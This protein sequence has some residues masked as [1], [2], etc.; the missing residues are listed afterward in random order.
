[1]ATLLAYLGGLCDWRDDLKPG[2]TGTGLVVAADLRQ[3]RSVLSYAEGALMGGG[4]PLQ[5]VIVSRTADAIQLKNNIVL[6]A[7]SANFRRLRG[8]TAIAVVADEIAFWRTDEHAANPDTE[9]L[10]A[11]RPCLATTG[12]PL[13]AA[14]SPYARRGE[15]YAAYRSH[16]GRDGDPRILVA[17]AA[18]RILNP[19][20]PQS[21][22]DRAMER[23]PA[24]ARAEYGAEFRS[25]VESFIPQETVDAS[26]DTG[27]TLRQPI[28]TVRYVGFADPA[29]GGGK[30]AFTGAIAHRESDGTLILD[31]LY[32]RRPPF[33][34]DEVA[35]E[36][37]A[38]FRRYSVSAITG[39]RFGG[40]FPKTAFSRAGM[41][42]TAS[43]KP[44]SDLY[45]ELLP[46]LS[47]GE[48]RLLDNP[49]LLSQLTSLERKTA[50]GGRDSIDHA[51]GAHDD[52]I[53]AAA[54]ALLAAAKQRPTRPEGVQTLRGLF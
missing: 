18:S 52:V 47:A 42:Y 35:S 13:I 30:D 32:E 31:L 44:K 24:S 20:L 51:P 10:A 12:G 33:N 3:A 41:K 4:V 17:Q 53:N 23:D 38:I 36:L 9:I 15:L 54:G 11:A 14:S 29:G 22:V 8:L 25:D 34:P 46:R 39:D 50:R 1:M 7:R 2:E 6:E 40:D 21:V 45:R 43:A 37:A 28:K 26:T 27:V 19:S 49:R 5:G 16:H 48:V